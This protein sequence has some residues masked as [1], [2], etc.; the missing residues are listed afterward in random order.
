MCLYCEEEDLIFTGDLVFPEGGFGR[1]DLEEGDREALIESIEKIVDLK[2][3]KMFCGHDE[4]AVEN[5]KEQI[6]E[7]LENAKKREPKY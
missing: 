5:V 1:T 6:R 2:I 3:Q 7:S 4:K